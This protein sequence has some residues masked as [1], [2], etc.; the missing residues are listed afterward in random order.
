[1]G[2]AEQDLLEVEFGRRSIR[3]LTASEVAAWFHALEIE[4][5]LAES[6]LRKTFVEATSSLRAAGAT[7]AVLSD[8]DDAFIQ[9]VLAH[10]RE[11]RD[12]A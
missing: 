2:I 3:E 8:E 11:I 5:D 1:L 4:L 7:T 6:A 9:D 10:L 12:L